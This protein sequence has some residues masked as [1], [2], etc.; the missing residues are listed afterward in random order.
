MERG[1]ATVLVSDDRVDIWIGDQSLQERRFS[2]SKITGI[3]E[4]NVHRVPGRKGASGRSQLS[5]RRS[6]SA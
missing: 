6:R 3:P 2:A 1:N 5:R 4:T